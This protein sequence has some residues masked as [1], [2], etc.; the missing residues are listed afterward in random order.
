MTWQLSTRCL[1]F[2]K[3]RT[4]N[5]LESL[6]WE[7]TIRTKDPKECCSTL[8]VESAKTWFWTTSKLSDLH[9]LQIYISPELS[10]RR[11]KKKWMW[12]NKKAANQQRLRHK[13]HSTPKSNAGSTTVENGCPLQKV[14]E[15]ET[16]QTGLNRWLQ[17]MTMLTSTR[18]VPVVPFSCCT[19][20]STSALKVYQLFIP[21]LSQQAHRIHIT[22]EMNKMR[23]NCFTCNRKEDP[24]SLVS[25]CKKVLDLLPLPLNVPCSPTMK[26]KSSPNLMKTFTSATTSKPTEK[27][28]SKNEHP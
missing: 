3:S 18:W 10:R 12:E 17:A 22:I 7:N 14:E 13:D 5:W 11:K 19:D 4:E 20:S 21:R 15:N 24:D 23:D 16:G 27:T 28:R 2:Q 25:V 8:K 9:E 1:P 6:G 26:S